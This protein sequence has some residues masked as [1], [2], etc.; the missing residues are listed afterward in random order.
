M[1]YELDR[2][3]PVSLY[4]HVP[5]C[6]TKCGY[7][8]FYSL[9]EKAVCA[10]EKDRFFNTLIKQI[11]SLVDY[12]GKP[13]YTVFVGGGNP[14]MLGFERLKTV[15]E[16]ASRFGRSR[17][18]TI[19]IN[20]EHVSAELESLLP[21][22]T[23]ISCGIQSFSDEALKVLGRNADCAVNRKALS[24]L[25]SLQK[26]H[27]IQFNGDLITCIPGHTLEGTLADID[28]LAGFSPDHIS[29]YALTFEEG[30]RLTAEEVPLEDEEQES[31]LT[32]CWRRLSE[33]GYEQY[34]VSN[35]ARDGHYCLHNK[36]YWSLGQYIGLGPSAESSAGYR[37]IVSSRQAETLDEY[38]K[39]PS[40]HSIVLTENE[41]EEEFLLAALRT[42]D[43]IDKA[44]F[45]SRFGHDFDMCF[46]PFI[47]RLDPSLYR[48]S[49]ASFSVT[50]EGFMVLD[51]IIL[52]LAMA[53]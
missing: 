31:I 38:L 6:T 34:E 43:G 9:P 30:T 18:C 11:D 50:A 13:F 20:P 22:V 10:D 12:L 32:S 5:F 25:S 29:L 23:R 8:A 37:N 35:F 2:E 4:I 17:E 44:E 24:I 39:D 53:I 33:L 3:R 7:C 27:G 52:E 26:K 14:A 45:I 21:Y 47:E 28:A 48:N 1:A 41:G 42:K 51:S 15:L 16:H 19:E 36:V 49:A 46:A 40:F